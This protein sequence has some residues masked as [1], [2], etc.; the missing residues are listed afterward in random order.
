M[1]YYQRF[2][3]SCLSRENPQSWLSRPIFRIWK[4]YFLEQWT[5][6]VGRKS[7]VTSHDH[8]FVNSI[9]NRM[10]ELTN[11]GMIDKSMTFDEYLSWKKEKKQ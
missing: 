9:A 7:S 10:I 5:D 11:N 2:T 6:R 4:P 3:T 1:L 8:Q